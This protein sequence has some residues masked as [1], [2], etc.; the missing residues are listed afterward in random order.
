VNVTPRNLTVGAA[1]HIAAS[2]TGGFGALAFHLILDL[3]GDDELVNG[4]GSWNF[5]TTGAGEGIV[6][7]EVT[8]QSGRTGG[9]G[10][11]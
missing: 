7:H 2:A 4:P 10:C 5:T 6:S 9:V 1:V 8:D 11:C 3:P